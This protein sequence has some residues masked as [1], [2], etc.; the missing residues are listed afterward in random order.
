MG[1]IIAPLYARGPRISA[2]VGGQ[3]AIPSDKGSFFG[4]NIHILSTVAPYPSQTTSSYVSIAQ[5]LGMKWYRNNVT[6]GGG[7]LQLRPYYTAMRA[8]G[9]EPFTVVIMEPTSMNPVVQLA[10][11]YTANYNSALQRG[12]DIGQNL[13]GYCTYFETTNELDYK[14]RVDWPSTGQ[15]RGDGSYVDGSRRTDFNA[16]KIDGWFG[17]NTGIADG[18][19]TYIPDAKIGFATGAG[20]G[21]YIVGEMWKKGLDTNGNVVRSGYPIDFVGMHWYQSMGNPRS[22][23]PSGGSTTNVFQEVWNRCGVPSFLSEWGSSPSDAPD[24]ATQA[25]QSSTSM[26][27]YWDNRVA[28]HLAGAFFYALFPNPGDST[29]ANWGIINADGTTH[30]QVYTTFKNYIAS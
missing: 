16:S 30:R 12:K 19:K 26:A 13:A 21:G 29:T 1:R 17:W 3:I 7:A 25:S 18:L 28:D 22:A 27:R 6:D 2:G 10:D 24:Q 20:F 8:A 11:G 14:C 15:Q 5:D 4:A 9:I 23:V